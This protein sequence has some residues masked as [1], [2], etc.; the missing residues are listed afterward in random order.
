MGS[1]TFKSA[2]GMNFSVPP[3]LG[4]AAIAHEATPSKKAPIRAAEQMREGNRRGRPLMAGLLSLK[5]MLPNYRLN[6][7]SQASQALQTL[8]LQPP[9]ANESCLDR[10]KSPRLSHI[11][12]ATSWPTIPSSLNRT[13]PYIDPAT[14]Q[15]FCRK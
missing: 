2:W 4:S 9:T 14:C 13:P 3:F 5:D 10:G 8:G 1:N 11:S 12:R 6:P 15:Q 7:C